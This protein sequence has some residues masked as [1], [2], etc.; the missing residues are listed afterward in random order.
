ML[1]RL[2]ATPIEAKQYVRK[3]GIQQ[4]NYVQYHA[5][6]LDNEA[7]AVLSKNTRRRVAVM[8]AS[9]FSGM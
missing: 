4:R 2:D 6:V 8:K 9:R 5:Q 1:A 3:I 7:V